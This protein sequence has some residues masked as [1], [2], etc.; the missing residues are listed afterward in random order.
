MSPKSEAFGKGSRCARLP[1]VLVHVIFYAS[2]M[3][4]DYVTS[5]FRWVWSIAQY[6]SLEGMNPAKG[7]KILVSTIVLK[8]SKYIKK[9]LN[10]SNTW[11]RISQR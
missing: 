9:Y 7:K 11:L 1:S 3:L 8:R 6:L 2:C 5:V 10:V 4:T